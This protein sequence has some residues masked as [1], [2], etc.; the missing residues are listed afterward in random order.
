MLCLLVSPSVMINLGRINSCF[1]VIDVVP[2]LMCV[3]LLLR[4]HLTI[5]GSNLGRINSCFVVID[6]VPM[7]MCLI[8][9]LRLHL[10]ICGSVG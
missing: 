7:L 4:L 6:V 8:L 3:I 9:L 5:C 1:V 10:T 2:M